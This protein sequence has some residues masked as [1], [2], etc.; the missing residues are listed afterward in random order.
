MSDEPVVTGAEEGAPE[1]GEGASEATPERTYLSDD[2]TDHYVRVK[3]DGED[4]EVPLSEALQGYSRQ[5]DYTRKTQQL[6]EQQREMQFAVTLQRA[7]ENNPQATLRLLQE[8]YAAPEQ[9]E[10]DW[11]ELDPVE[12][13]LRQYDQR[14]EYLEQQQ[15]HQEL[16][17]AV[18]VL[19]QRY[20]EDFNPQAVV[21]RAAEQQR[22]DLENVFKEMAFERFWS[23]RAVQSQR[24]SDD[25]ARV[26]AKSQVPV[27]TG[28]SVN[29]AVGEEPGQALSVADAFHQAKRQLGM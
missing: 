15:A 9:V 19:Q 25:A 22:M 17:V 16:Q 29:G 20:G 2:Y 23:D 24:Q 10:D 21:Q 12:Q 13:R 28:S 27:H 7:L 14:V 11:E 4:Q 5:Q 3:V 8:Q 6:A 1:I 26:A 18:R